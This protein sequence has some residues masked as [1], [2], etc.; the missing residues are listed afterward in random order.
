MCTSSTKIYLYT[1]PLCKIVA[2]KVNLKERR[3]KIKQ[4]KYQLLSGILQTNIRPLDI[5]YTDR[6]KP[7]VINQEFSFSISHSQEF[8]AIAW[9][10]AKLELGLDIESLSRIV[11][12]NFMRKV[13]HQ[14]EWSYLIGRG[15]KTSDFLY[16]WA[17][18]EAFIKAK[19]LHI[20]SGLKN[21][22]FYPIHRSLEENLV[23]GT[24]DKE[25][26]HMIP[27]QFPNHIGVI[28]CNKSDVALLTNKTLHLTIKN[29]QQQSI[30]KGSL[31]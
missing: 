29:Y 8:Y 14:I 12:L 28:C 3:Q 4:F 15:Q 30:L 5:G 23:I 22:V 18:K 11:S 10:Y 9:T 13:L 19:G 20:F 25:R 26:Y 17:Q 2:E 1:I 27:I 7:F 6:G 24:H 16:L 31:C 21:L